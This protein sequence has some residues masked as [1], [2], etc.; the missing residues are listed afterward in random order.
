MKLL[1]IRLQ[2]TFI[3]LLAFSPLLYLGFKKLTP[4][5]S[6]YQFDHGSKQEPTVSP[7]KTNG[8]NIV[9]ELGSLV[10]LRGVNLIS[11]K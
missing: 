1:I 8:K 5:I 7:L 2:I 11:T 6:L 4:Q 10:V 9:D 3:I